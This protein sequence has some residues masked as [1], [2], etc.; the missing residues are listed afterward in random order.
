LPVVMVHWSE[1][2][3]DKFLDCVAL[4]RNGVFEP[5]GVDLGA[6]HLSARYGA[7]ASWSLAVSRRPNAS[8]ASS[9]SA[10]I[11]A[12]EWDTLAGVCLERLTKGG[13]ASSS[14]C[15]AARALAQSKEREPETI[16]R[17]YPVERRSLSGQLRQR[18][19]GRQ[20]PPRRSRP[21]FLRIAMTNTRIIGLDDCR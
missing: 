13:R 17:L 4:G 16:L 9:I 12:H 5:G 18:V 7:T 1:A 11:I 2:L 19:W 14:P 6:G 20:G 8:S 15:G 21:I 3:A 10:C